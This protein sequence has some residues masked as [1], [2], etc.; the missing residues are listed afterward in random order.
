MLVAPT[1]ADLIDNVATFIFPLKIWWERIDFWGALR[2]SLT[3]VGLDNSPR[4]RYFNVCGDLVNLYPTL[5]ALSPADR[6]EQARAFAEN[7]Y[8]GNLIELSVAELYTDFIAYAKVHGVE[9]IGIRY[10]QTREYSDA[11][12]ELIDPNATA[13][14]LGLGVPILDY[15]GMF[16]DRP[17]LFIDSDHLSDEGAELLSRRVADDVAGIL[18]L[19]QRPP[20]ACHS[21]EVLRARI[22]PYELMLRRLFMQSHE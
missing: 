4:Q 15:R 18:S 20:W 19:P 3:S 11:A 12:G 7:R 14:L 13:F 8:K 22:W 21:A 16:Q 10:P 2:N 6:A 1:R 5:D 9:V 17:G